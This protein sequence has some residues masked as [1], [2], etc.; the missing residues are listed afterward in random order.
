MIVTRPITLYDV[1]GANNLE[2]KVKR[3]ETIN[4]PQGILI[5]RIIADTAPSVTVNAPLAGNR[6]VDI[7]K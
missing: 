6:G 3:C 7:D 5:S 4:R 2:K 1:S